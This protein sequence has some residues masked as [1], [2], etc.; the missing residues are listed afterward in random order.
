MGMPGTPRLPSA[1]G[2]T[3]DG[4]VVKP[5]TAKPV[6]ETPST[7][8]ALFTAV[9]PWTPAGKS[10]QNTQ[11]VPARPS[12]PDTPAEPCPGVPDEM[13]PETPAANTAVLAFTP[14]I[15]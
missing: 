14:A 9:K 2:S 11:P 4:P 1:T 15:A 12:R 3:L 6:V 5:S 13:V 7:P 10:K 8:V